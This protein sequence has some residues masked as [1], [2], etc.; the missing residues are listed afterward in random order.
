MAHLRRITKHGS[1]TLTLAWGIV[2]IRPTLKSATVDFGYSSDK[3]YDHEKYDYEIELSP[4]EL[5][6]AINNCNVA[7]DSIDLTEKEWAEY[8]RLA[9]KMLKV[10]P[11]I[12]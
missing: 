4:H 5:V 7:G 8:K 10:K 1:R 6:R 9:A 3:R 11:N 2:G 12:K